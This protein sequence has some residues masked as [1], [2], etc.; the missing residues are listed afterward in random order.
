VLLIVGYSIQ[1]TSLGQ[2][3]PQNF[4]PK[5][6]L[7]LCRNIAIICRALAFDIF[8]AT[9]KLKQK[10]TTETTTPLFFVNNFYTIAAIQHLQI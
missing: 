8:L 2:P 4:L 1:N 3:Q 9:Q 5:A 6:I 7:G 10:P